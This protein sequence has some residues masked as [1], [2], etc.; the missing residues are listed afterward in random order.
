MKSPRIA[1]A[2]FGAALVFAL[3]SAGS[4]LAA[5]K[6][7]EFEETE[8]G[9]T[10]AYVDNAPTS[11][12]KHGFPTKISAGDMIVLNNPLLEGGKRIGHLSVSCVATKTSN[13]FDGAQF[14][15]SGTFVLPGGTLIASAM[16]SGQSATE[17]AIVGGTGKYGGARGT[18]TTKETKGPASP[19]TVTLLE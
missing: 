10:F 4:A 6:T 2:V 12:L 17:G 19:V 11:P 7:I 13:K 5:T 18:F 8:K 16:I 9:A 3:L 14:N 1:L 15:C